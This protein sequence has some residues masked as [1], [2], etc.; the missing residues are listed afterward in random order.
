MET[1]QSS[2]TGRDA[3]A[4]QVMDESRDKAHQG[5]DKATQAAGPAVDR[6]SSSAHGAVDRISSY[7]SQ[8]RE[9]FSGTASHYKD[10]QS[11][12][13]ADT[14]QRI[15]EQPMAALAI[16]AAAGFLLRSLLRGRRHHD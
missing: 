11:Q 10:M 6:L 4:Q 13:V 8:A 9:R 3:R 12:V 5:I 16:A 1:P 15:R 14:R 7:A 2:T